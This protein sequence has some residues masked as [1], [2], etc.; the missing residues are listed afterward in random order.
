MCQFITNHCKHEKKKSKKCTCDTED[1][2][3]DGLG[4]DTDMLLNV[5]DNKCDLEDDQMEVAE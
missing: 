3:V 2:D 1:P 4:P 5:E